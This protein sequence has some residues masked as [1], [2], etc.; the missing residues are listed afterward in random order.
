MAGK[1]III[2][3]QEELKRVKIIHEVI[4]KS[5]TQKEA[6]VKIYISD[7]QIRRLLIRVKEEGDKGLAH[8][9]RGKKSNRR[10]PECEKGK[11]LE[12]CRIKY[13]G[14]GPT[15]CMEKL[16]EKE[17]IKISDETLREWFIKEEIEYKSRRKGKKFRKW[18]ER[19]EYFGEMIQIDGSHHDWLEGRGSKMV[20]MAFIDDATG[21]IFCRFY[22]Y[23]G[24][25]PA[26]DIMKRY[27]KRYGI[28]HSVY[29]DKH[30]AYKCKGKLSIEDELAGKQVPLSQY[31]RALKELKINV[32]HANSPQA[33]GRI[34]RLFNTL[35]DRLIKE[36]RLENIALLEEANE[37]LK[38]YMPVFNKKFAV[39]AAK[40][41]D[42]HR[43]IKGLNLD[44]I[45]CM[46]TERVIRNDFTVNHDKKFYQ[47]LDCIAAKKATIN[48][49]V[50]GSIFITSKGKRLKHKEIFPAKKKIVKDKPVKAK[51][52]VIQPVKTPVDY[53]W[54]RTMSTIFTK[55][56][57]AA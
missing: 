13:A 24:T 5:L 20:L 23:E 47:V 14:F 32:I 9:S 16:S 57:L 26:L 22:D 30:S 28:P 33:K 42:L 41:T 4:N 52:E 11:I 36:L 56:K 10:Y 44:E 39:K 55:E 19:K 45:L 49:S 50:T 53:S 17:K 15:L 27:I 6:A 7:R 48:E 1:D 31:E 51:K 8:K 25:I 12:I 35:Q 37:F 46:K 3:S 54:R 40:E 38:E 2:M 18:R 43:G 21:K 34:E 29:L